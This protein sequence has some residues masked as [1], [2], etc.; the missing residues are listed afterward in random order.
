MET[1]AREFWWLVALEAT[2]FLSLPCWELTATVAAPVNHPLRF[3]ISL[4]VAAAVAMFSC[5]VGPALFAAHFGARWP[6]LSWV[7]LVWLGVGYIEWLGNLARA[8]AEFLRVVPVWLT[9]L[10]DWSR[11]GVAASFL[12]IVTIAAWVKSWW[13]G[14]VTA[15]LLLGLGILV[16]VLATSWP[17]LWVRNPRVA[18]DLSHV[19]SYFIEGILLSAA[20]TIVIGWRIGRI[21]SRPAQVW[22]SGFAGVWLP[23]VISVTMASLATQAGL[24][25]YWRPSLFRDFDW[26]LIGA[27]GRLMPSMITLTALTLVSPA[28]LSAFSLKEMAWNWRHRLN[29]WLVPAMIFVAYPAMIF[30]MAVISH[31]ASFVKL[32]SPISYDFSSTF[33]EVWAWSL[34]IVGAIAGLASA[35]VPRSQ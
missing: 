24:N 32:G 29:V 25:L 19:D 9:N 12:A 2:L 35:A 26:A 21:E 11:F 30:V 1:R 22:L 3:G 31:A 33:H 20:P 16:W 8:E 34:V 6:R 15:G 18:S 10:S 27:N 13:K 28:L 7:P 4:V 17:G 5:H 14:V 23:A